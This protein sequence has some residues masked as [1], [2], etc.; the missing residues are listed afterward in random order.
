MIFFINMFY[1][2][3][4]PDDQEAPDD[5]DASPPEDT[6]LYPHSS[7]TQYQQVTEELDWLKLTM[8]ILKAIDVYGQVCSFTP[9]L[10]T[11]EENDAFCL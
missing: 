8:L 2:V 3:Q 7:G 1:V 10:K 11:P 5:H 6:T 4:E 9:S